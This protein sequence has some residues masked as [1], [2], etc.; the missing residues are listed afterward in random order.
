M[1][2][3][4][5]IVR[6]LMAQGMGRWRIAQEMSRILGRSVS[7]N[8]VRH[9]MD[10][11]RL[12]TPPSELASRL[13]DEVARAKEARNDRLL[14]ELMRER[15]R[16]E[17]ILETLRQTV[18]AM[19]AMDAPMPLS[20]A[21]ATGDA[22][23]AVALVSDVQI[24]QVVDP[25]LTGGLGGYSLDVFRARADRWTAAVA[26][27]TD[28]HRRAY[29]IPVLHLWML[30][31]MC[32]GVMIYRGQ[33][34]HLEATRL[35]QM[36]HGTQ[37]FAAAIVRLLQVYPRI[38]IVGLL[39]N[40]G[41]EGRKGETRIDDNADLMFYY[42]M[43]LLLSN[44]RDRVTIQIPQSW[45]TL[46]RVFDWRFLLVHG[47]DIRAWNQFPFYGLDRADGRYTKM[48]ASI[49]HRYEYMCI[50]HHH[51]PAMIDT[52]TGL[53]IANGSWVGTSDYAAKTMNVRSRASQWFFGVHPRRGVTWRYQV[54]LEAAGDEDLVPRRRSWPEHMEILR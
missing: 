38:E 39:G 15:T 46:A 14:R 3:P 30:G 12:E 33:E 36:L 52:P 20:L 11:V 48:L 47:D 26:K 2:E 1:D 9:W 22:E 37:I 6:S 18:L 43:S 27:I 7:R 5:E 42:V 8:T 34:W 49:G 25:V 4:L 40:H 10:R 41:R 53:Q 13:P 16:T 35:E 19:P 50:G 24:G 32:D 28:L 54:Q 51:H 44:Y 29:P 21:T 17:M 23:E 45:F 31:D